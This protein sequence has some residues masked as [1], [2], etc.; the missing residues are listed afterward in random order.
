M[1]KQ[2]LRLQFQERRRA[3]DSETLSDW[4]TSLFHQALK[5]P[6]WDYQ[7]FHL[8]LSI[9]NKKEVDTTPF[10]NHLR[11]L[12]REI[13]VPKI[14]AQGALTHHRLGPDT[15]LTP[16]AWGIPEPDS[17]NRVKPNLIDVVFVPLLAFDLK[18]N[19]VGYGGGY[20]DKF[21]SACRVDVI[22]VGLSLFEPVAEISGLYPGDVPLKYAVT[23]ERIFEF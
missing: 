9:S 20:Y 13:V 22:T 5:L 3:L 17:G 4:S 16:N 10:L 1:D 7:V 12:N 19:R 18:G 2:A 15:T 21:L 14:A 8:F 23:P 6:I 11:R